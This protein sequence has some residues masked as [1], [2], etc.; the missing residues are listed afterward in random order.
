M[1]LDPAYEDIGSGFVQQYYAMFDDPIQRPNLVN[2]Y[3][4][5]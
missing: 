3:N 2:L 5:S 4:V 1:A